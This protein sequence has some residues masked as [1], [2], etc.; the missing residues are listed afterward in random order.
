LENKDAAVPSSSRKMA[1]SRLCLLLLL[2]TA[3]A[4]A[5]PNREKRNVITDLVHGVSG[6]VNGVANTATNLLGGVSGLARN[7]IDESG[8]DIVQALLT[9]IPINGQPIGE[10][11]QGVIDTLTRILANLQM[12]SAPSVAVVG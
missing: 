9:K 2:S 4:A 1:S 10:I 12:T 8:D 11:L 7:F 3:I 6:T 5:S